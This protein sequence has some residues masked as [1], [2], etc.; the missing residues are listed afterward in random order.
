MAEAVQETMAAPVDEPPVVLS[1]DEV[2][3]EI[4]SEIPAEITAEMT[5]EVD[6]PPVVLSQDAA[7]AAAEE[8]RAKRQLAEAMNAR[9]RARAS[10]LLQPLAAAARFR[11]AGAS[12]ARAEADVISTVISA[13]SSAR[14]EAPPIL[15]G[16]R[17]D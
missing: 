14:A 15:P 3:A 16:M 4:T 5:A 10:V 2:T 11:S 13:A 7:A 8:R 9:T 1:Q 12:S 17:N 6:E